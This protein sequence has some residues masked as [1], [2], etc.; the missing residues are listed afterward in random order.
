MQRSW[1]AAIKLARRGSEDRHPG[2]EH[3]APQRRGNRLAIASAQQR[4]QGLV[5]GPRQMEQCLHAAAGIQPRAELPLPDRKLVN[6]T[7]ELRMGKRHRVG[8]RDFN[9][10]GW[11]WSNHDAGQDGYD[12][13]GR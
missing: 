7:A 13:E 5:A 12:R 4:E 11:S 6:W 9:G 2:T 10:V 8:A 1:R 3:E